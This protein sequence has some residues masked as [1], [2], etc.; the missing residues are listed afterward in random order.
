VLDLHIGTR[1]RL[2]DG[3]NTLAMDIGLVVAHIRKCRMASTA[4]MADLLGCSQARLLKLEK[5][6][7]A[8]SALSLRLI[9]RHAS[10]E[11]LLFLLGRALGTEHAALKFE[12]DAHLGPDGTPF[13][14]EDIG[15]I[16]RALQAVRG[17]SQTELARVLHISQRLIAQLEAGA[18]PDSIA[19]FI[20]V[21][22]L[23]REAA[24]ET[25]S[26]SMLTQDRKRR[27]HES[28]QEAAALPKLNSGKECRNHA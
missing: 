15:L 3:G 25:L 12:V 11:A 6:H 22:R 28:G 5:G 9:V 18:E 2:G 17:I 23:A 10:S 21:L 24:I 14:G 4:Q 8:L 27:R 1:S 26:K 16:I 20:R 19:I 13:D 7:T